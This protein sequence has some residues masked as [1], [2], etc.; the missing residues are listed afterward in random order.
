MVVRFLTW[1]TDKVALVTGKD[2]IKYAPTSL[3][4]EEEKRV[5]VIRQLDEDEQR[6]YVVLAKLAEEK[7]SLE[8][9]HEFLHLSGE[10]GIKDCLEHKKKISDCNNKLELSRK[11]LWE[12]IRISIPDCPDNLQI[13]KKWQVVEIPSENS[14]EEDL[15]ASLEKEFPGIISVQIGKGFSMA[16]LF[17]LNSKL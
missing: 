17:D 15:I 3:N 16:S 4:K 2:L 11:I 13:Q 12:S 14:F 9:E 5:K 10:C 8:K 6:L 7:T 1:L